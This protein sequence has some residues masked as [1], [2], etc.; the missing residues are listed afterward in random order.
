MS[1]RAERAVFAGMR[2][3]ARIRRAADGQCRKRVPR[4][5]N[6]NAGGRH[7]QLGRE[8]GDRLAQRKMDGD[9]NDGELRRPQHHHRLRCASAIG[10]Q[11]GEKLGVA[12]MAEAGAVEHALGDRIGDDG[13]GA[14]GADVVDRMADGGERGAGAGCVGLSGA[15]GGYFAGCD[16]G[17]RFREM[18]RSRLQV[19]ASARSTFNP[20]IFARARQRRRD[21][22]ADRTAEGQARCAA[23]TPRARCRGRCPQA[24]RMSVRGALPSINDIRSSRLFG[25]RCR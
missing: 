14:P 16:H 7:D 21:R 8:R 5:G 24:R 3:E 13:A 1:S 6:G 15:G 9:R 2:V 11:L 23:A 17:Q 22:R 4:S 19:P 18:P 12:G 25:C 10:R 20:R